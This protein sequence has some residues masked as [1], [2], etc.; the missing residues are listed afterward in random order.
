MRGFWGKLKTHT[1]LL[2]TGSE[3]EQKK[4]QLTLDQMA[5]REELHYKTY[6]NPKRQVG[7]LVPLNNPRKFVRTPASRMTMR[8]KDLLH[9]DAIGGYEWTRTT[10]PS[11]MNAF[12]ITSLLTTP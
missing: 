7:L 9:D 1:S 2:L 10:D 4:C 11:M 8:K 3:L 6:V 5:G 12:S